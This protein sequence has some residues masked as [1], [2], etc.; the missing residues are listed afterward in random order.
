[1]GKSIGS[2]VGGLLSCNA[3]PSFSAT[4]TMMA[5]QDKSCELLCIILLQG[6]AGS[7]YVKFMAKLEETDEVLK[8]DVDKEESVTDSDETC[9]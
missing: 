3:G 8:K 1:M 6:L 4:D 9:N 7:R 2:L 5:S